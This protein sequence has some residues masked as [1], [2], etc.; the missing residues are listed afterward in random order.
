MSEDLFRLEIREADTPE[1][2]SKLRMLAVEY[3]QATD[4]YATRRKASLE[5]QHDEE[6]LKAT[7]SAEKQLQEKKLK[8]EIVER[9]LAERGYQIKLI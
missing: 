1:L 6:L 5:H 3:M 7:D 2:M 8:Y 9:E 4:Q